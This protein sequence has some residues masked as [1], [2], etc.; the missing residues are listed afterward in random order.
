MGSRQSAS[1]EESDGQVERT[2][3]ANH[4]KELGLV[5]ELL[6]AYLSGFSKIGSFT[7]SS[8]NELEYAWLLLVTRSFNSMRCA[9]M[10]LQKGYYTQAATLV[11]SAYE[12]WLI[13]VDCQCNRETLD[14]VLRGKGRLGRGKLAYSQMAKRVSPDFEKVWRDN[15]GQ[16][17]TIAHPRER[18]LRI[19]VDPKMRDLGLGGIY[20][21]ALFDGTC[22]AFVLVADKMLEFLARLLDN[23][24]GPPA[25]EW[26][27]QTLPNA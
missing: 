3:L 15:Y 18:S 7:L 11:R 10:C 9:Q 26:L 24:L 12:D 2:I 6:N 16:L 4:A 5:N 19:L 17:S 21:E 27:K 8:Q 22:D 23:L 20:D 25:R 14:A 1:L 13:C